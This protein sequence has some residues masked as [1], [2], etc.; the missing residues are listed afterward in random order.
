MSRNG[1][2]TG[3]V[4]SGRKCV[5]RSVG[6]YHT[7]QPR[8]QARRR[9]VRD[10]R[11]RPLDGSLASLEFFLVTVVIPIREVFEI[12]GDALLSQGL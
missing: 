3:R 11:G 4:C 12:K 9:V 6:S 1:A 8:A 7:D 10:V 5:T 2:G